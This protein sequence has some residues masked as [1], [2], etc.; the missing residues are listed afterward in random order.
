MTGYIRV[1]DML[2]ESVG[3]LCAWLFFLVGI[4]VCYEVVMRDLFTAPTVWVDEVV[5]IM[6]IWLTYL[7]AA[8]VLKHRNMITIDIAFRRHD[9]T[10]RQVVETLAL[11]IMLIFAGIASWYGFQLWLKS[12]LAGHTTDSFL[13]IP[14]W[15]TQSS[16]WVGF[17]LLGLQGIADIFR[18]WTQG[19]PAPD[20]NVLDKV[21]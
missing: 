12:T 16:I 2:T 21:D 8:Y 17:G 7:A 6:Q 4:F 13:A 20:E 9:T 1:I 19:V 3:K 18:V 10:A 5:R 15:L 11:I 14:K